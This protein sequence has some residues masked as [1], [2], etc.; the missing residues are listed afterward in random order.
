MW[1]SSREGGGCLV[2]PVDVAF[3]TASSDFLLD[4]AELHWLRRF[5]R[6]MAAT[7]E[8]GLGMA[9]ALVGA[10][11]LETEDRFGRLGVFCIGKWWKLG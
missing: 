11:F 2:A 5:F 8:P 3:L 9:S 4:P 7:E 10:D 1:D 6:V